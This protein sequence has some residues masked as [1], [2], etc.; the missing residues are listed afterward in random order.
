MFKRF[1]LKAIISV[2]IFSFAFSFPSMAMAEESVAE[3]KEEL[4]QMRRSMEQMQARIDELERKTNRPLV[5]SPVEAP[6]EVVRTPAT[7]P[8][9]VGSVIPEIGVIADFVATACESKSDL[10]GNNRLAAREVEIVVGG[11][12]DP[13]SRLDATLAFSDFE[14]TSLEE[15]Y[16]TRWG[17]PFDLTARVGRFSPRAGKQAAL[18]RDSLETVDEPLVI[19]NFFGVEGYRKSGVDFARAL[20]GPAGLFIEPSVGVLEGGV[21]EGG[22]LFGATRRRP[23]FIS[24]LKTAKD[25]TDSSTLEFGLTHMAGSKDADAAFEVN[26]VGVDATYINRLN[27]INRLKLQSEFFLQHRDEAF[28]IN[29]TTGANTQFDRN[30]WGAYAL[31]EYKFAP[32]WAIGA[33][34]DHVRIVDAVAT[35]HA[36]S[37]FSTFLTFFQSE[38]ARWRLQY[39]HE[40]RAQQKDEEAFFL[41]GTFALGT[42]KHKLQ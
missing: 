23:T 2:F 36:D 37:G 15:A 20:E 14:A 7:L 21:G 34:G 12:V 30:P 11:Y 41:Q 9:Q 16:L 28:S 29:E 42:H 33:R 17:L 31:A 19:R 18:H 40:E 27:G 35:R 5:L 32:R 25:L 13:Y 1:F 26:M 22:N 4:A 3:L 8:G 6:T 24:H 10:E 39:R 38:W